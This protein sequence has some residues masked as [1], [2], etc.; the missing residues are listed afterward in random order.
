MST[1][2][3]YIGSNKEFCQPEKITLQEHEL[4]FLD[5]TNRVKTNQIHYEIFKQAFFDIPVKSFDPDTTS[6]NIKADH[7][8][9][10]EAFNIQNFSS[11]LTD[12]AKN[13]AFRPLRKKNA[14]EMT[15]LSNKELRFK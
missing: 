7:E 2:E 13:G 11:E 6:M 12:T 14:M 1:G 9:S 8:S 3:R 10:N 5:K 4:N 15:L